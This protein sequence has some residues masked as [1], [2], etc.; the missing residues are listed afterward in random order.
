[1]DVGQMDRRAIV[2]LLL[3][4]DRHHPIGGFGRCALSQFSIRG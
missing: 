1:M 2:F 4:E 3:L